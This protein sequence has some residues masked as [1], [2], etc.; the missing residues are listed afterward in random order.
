M[1]D[2]RLV[3]GI[4]HRAGGAE[5][6]CYVVAEALQYVMGKEEWMS[7]QVWHEGTSHWFLKHKP[8]G[9]ILDP[10]AIQFETPVPYDKARHVPFL[11]P[12]PCKR[13][14]EVLSK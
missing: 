11:T 7:M 6:T 2:K 12:E 10:T 8:T 3:R 1:I 5:G 9:T 13:T 4:V 14:M